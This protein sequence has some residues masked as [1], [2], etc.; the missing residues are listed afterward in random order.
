MRRAAAPHRKRAGRSRA[1]SRLP[2]EGA[3]P[4]NASEVLKRFTPLVEQWSSGA[5]AG[6]MVRLG[7]RS[8]FEAGAGAVRRGRLS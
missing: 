1:A 6:P 3:A 8:R 4:R 2:S 7:A 5:V